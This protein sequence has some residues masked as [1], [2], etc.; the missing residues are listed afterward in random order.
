MEMMEQQRMKRKR[1]AGIGAST[2]AA[3]GKMS[4]HKKSR[5]D[6]VQQ[7]QRKHQKP[8]FV[9]R[10]AVFGKRGTHARSVSIPEFAD[11][12]AA[13]MNLRNATQATDPTTMVPTPPSPPVTTATT[14]EPPVE[15]SEAYA[16][17]CSL[18][19][20]GEWDHV[21]M[22]QALVHFQQSQLRVQDGKDEHR[23]GL[24]AINLLY[25]VCSKVRHTIWYIY[26]Y[27]YTHSY[28]DS[29]AYIRMN[30]KC[31]AAVSHHMPLPIQYNRV[32]PKQNDGRSIDGTLLTCV[33]CQPSSHSLCSPMYISP[34]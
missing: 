22:F 4:T 29:H 33:Y 3:D 30:M 31:S 27:I 9:R 1:D 32:H 21:D 15:V 34:G 28:I 7:Q 17:Y 20:A 6:V 16:V 5:Q 14:M 10:R 19:R 18:I 23:D 13:A 12:A 24:G 26:I 2:R 11:F 25:F 8:K